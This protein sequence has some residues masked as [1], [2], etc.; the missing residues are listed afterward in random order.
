[1]ID[2]AMSVISFYLKPD[3]NT[4][5]MTTSK[6]FHLNNKIKNFVFLT[7]FQTCQDMHIVAMNF[8][9]DEQYGYSQ[10]NKTLSFW[11][12]S[13]GYMHKITRPTA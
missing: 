13:H 4:K 6:R 8:R 12:Y 2:F 10:P 7:G 11:R 9:M 3:G 1:M 5:T